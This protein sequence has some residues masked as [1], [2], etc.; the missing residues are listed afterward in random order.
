MKT[1]NLPSD[2]ESKFFTK[3]I[4]I[5]FLVSLSCSLLCFGYELFN[6]SFSID[7][8][9]AG[10][11]HYENLWKG[12]L[13]Q[14]RWGMGFIVLL[15]PADISYMPFVPTA[16]F[17][18]GICLAAV[19][20]SGFYFTD[21]SSRAAFCAIFVSNPIMPH[22]VQFNTFAHGVGLG[23]LLCAI[24]LWMVL[25]RRLLLNALSII[26]FTMAVG[27]YQSFIF[28]IFAA[29]LL[30]FCIKWDWDFGKRLV[31]VCSSTFLVI[32]SYFF[33]GLIGKIALR[34]FHL[35]KSDYFS[36]YIDLKDV[37]PSLNTSIEVSWEILNGS[38][39]FYLDL[40]I[41]VLLPVWIGLITLIFAILFR[42]NI[43]IL[44][45]GLSLL[46]MLGALVVCYSLV[47]VSSGRIPLRALL[48]F[49]ILLPFLAAF[50]MV[51]SKFRIAFLPI[52]ILSLACS[53]FISNE[54]FNKDR[55]ARIRD[56]TLALA[57]F[58]RLQNVE[59]SLGTQPIPF[60]VIGSPSFLHEQNKQIE[61][62]GSSFFTHDGGNPFRV[63][64]Y[65]KSLGISNL[66]PIAT[67]ALADKSAISSRPTWPH[68]DSVFKCGDALVVKF[69]DIIFPIDLENTKK[70]LDSI[71]EQTPGAPGRDPILSPNGVAI[72]AGMEP[73]VVKFD[74]AGKFKKIDLLA[75]AVVPNDAPSIAG[76][77]GV[78]I[79]VD[80]I[81]Q[82]RKVVARQ[83]KQLWPLNVENA[84]ELKLVVDNEN[85]SDFWD[86]VEF[87][88]GP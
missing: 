63:A 67:N 41:W 49:T 23:Y 46:L 54:F 3:E 45:I 48:G 70:L 88:V 38:R 22:L 18:L 32:I 61:V 15:L 29:V 1:D 79:F 58:S 42:K 17:C 33:S 11:H 62:F 35:N 27:I 16:L 20:C 21:I 82:G 78:E 19:I 53:I 68:P 12:W 28:F 64:A 2:L 31:L 72:S 52:I 56:H 86:W 39:N 77:T 4:K 36:N 13:Q 73:A 75:R 85:G 51:F 71:V 9:L 69:E 50:P 47:F 40:G 76:I 60:S 59:P 30:K 8:E 74:V 80:G 26:P 34:I 10:Y 6:F 25:D 55:L 43:N 14:G 57:L 65:L 37:I 83:N 44:Q 81:T 84:K 66:N 87:S 24:G 5:L 7:E